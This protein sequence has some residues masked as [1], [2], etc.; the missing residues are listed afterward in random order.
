[1]SKDFENWFDVKK[2]LDALEKAPLFKEREIWWC[3]VGVNVGYEI[4]GKG[5]IFTRPVLVLKKFS[6]FTFFGAPLTSS[7]KDRE[8][9]YSFSYRGRN[10]AINFEQ[11]RVYDARRLHGKLGRIS[12]E[13]FQKIKQALKDLL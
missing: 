3:S 8:G 9:Y 1:M 5:H 4:Y 10:G 7:D 2:G 13:Q 12:P 6:R 11:M